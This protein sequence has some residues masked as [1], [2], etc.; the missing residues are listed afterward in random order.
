MALRVH[1]GDR[2]LMRLCT[3][4]T[5]ELWEGKALWPPS[6]RA[7]DGVLSDVNDAGTVATLSSASALFKH[8]RGEHKAV[9]VGSLVI[10]FGRGF[11][12]VQSVTSNT[13]IILEA[14]TGRPSTAFALAA[15]T[16][17]AF[18]VGGYA[19]Q[20]QDAYEEV[21]SIPAMC[22]REPLDPNP[23]GYDIED[24]P[25]VDRALYIPDTWHGA[26][27]VVKWGALRNVLF[28]LHRGD[29][30]VYGEKY[31]LASAEY[32]RQLAQ[33]DFKYALSN[34]EIVEQDLPS[35]VRFIR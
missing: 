13:A 32:D 26:D 33:L 15:A 19:E 18:Q 31:T 5:D 1:V 16:G 9:P 6:G 35:T 20:V 7:T 12:Y 8:A 23:L 2:E 30:T 4:L 25:L 28:S 17:V 10:L 29:E 3:E 27:A 11:Y 21:W 34:G 24:M 22:K 14:D